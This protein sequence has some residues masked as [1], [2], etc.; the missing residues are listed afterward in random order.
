MD[1]VYVQRLSAA[2]SARGIGIEP[3]LS[4][5]EIDRVQQLL[6]A[7]LPPDARTL[8]T[9]FLPASQGFPDWRGG[10]EEELRWRCDGPVEGVL[11]DVEV[12]AFWLKEWGTRPASPEEAANVARRYLT[13]VPR[14]LP[15]WGHRYLPCDPPIAGNPVFSIT[16]TDVGSR[17]N[18]DVFID[19]DTGEAYPELPSG[20]P[21]EDSIGNI[22]D[23]LPELGE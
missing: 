19:T 14:L 8:L 7:S 15:L 6:G 1:T 16:Q 21:A 17:S 12:N 3:G 10:S 13:A 18:P 11:F 22:F 4:P 23:Y 5:A 9:T 20:D 2:L